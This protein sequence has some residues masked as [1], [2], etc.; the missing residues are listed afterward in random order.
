MS[1]AL[2]LTGL[3]KVGALKDYEIHHE[4]EAAPEGPVPTP[5]VSG[6]CFAMTRADFAALGGFDEGYFLHVEDVDLC[7]R[8]RQAGGAVLFQPQARVVHLGST[9]RKARRG[10]QGLRPGPLLPQAGG[11]RA[12]PV[13][14]LAPV[15][16][17]HRGIGGAGAAASPA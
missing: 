11:D 5:T 12:G 14:R 1:T 3:A 2:S 9:A 8:V 16:R 10:E 13:R 17:H 15:P 7:W 4:G 6:A